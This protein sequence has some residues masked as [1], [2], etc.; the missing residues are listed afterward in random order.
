LI[1]KPPLLGLSRLRGAGLRQDWPAR[2]PE[3]ERASRQGKPFLGLFA[4]PGW[5]ASA[6]VLV[7]S[8]SILIYLLTRL[9]GL[10]SFPIF[11]FSDEAVQTVMAADFVR[12]DFR[13]YDQV[14]L[15]TYFINGPTYNLSSVSVYLQVVP[16]LLFGKSI[17]VTRSVSVAAGV[18]AA[19]AVALS[20]R[21]VFKIPFWWSGILLLSITPAWFYHS[22]TA[23]EAV[24]MTAFYAAFLYFYLQ[25]R[26][27][28]PRFLYPALFF[29]ALT[30]YTYGPGQIIMVVSGLLL[31]FSDLGYH[32]RNRW[33]GV[34]GLVLLAVLAL[35]YLRFILG[36][37]G[38]P[39]DQL[40][41]RAPFWVQPA[42]LG[43][44][45]TRFIANYLG[46]INPLYWYFPQKHEL[47]R[48]LM[49]G[50]GHLFWPAIPLT[51]VGLAAAIKNFRLPAYR[52]LWIALAAV[53]AGSA[54]VGV[55]ITRLLP[56][57]IPITIFTALG[58]SWTICRLRE[59]LDSSRIAG[60]PIKRP[61]RPAGR[62]PVGY[63]SLVV[64]SILA[65]IN[66][67]MLRDGLVNGATWFQDYSLNGMQY[68]ARQ[69]FS[70][71]QETLERGPD[72]EIILSPTW[73]NGADVVARFFLGDPLPIQMG[74]I[75]GHLMEKRTLTDRTLFIMTPEEYQ[76]TLESEKF[77]R[78][79][80]EQIIP[81]PNGEPGF[82]FTRLAY[83]DQIDHI[84]AEEREQRRHLVE[85]EISFEGQQ[86][87][88]RHSQLDIGEI[89]QLFD[90]D[91]LSP[92]RTLEANPFV[93]EIAFSE[94][95]TIS[96]ISLKVSSIEAGLI[97][98][99]YPY[100]G[101]EALEFNDV[102]RGTVER[103]E[104]QLDFGQSVSTAVFHLE[105]KDIHQPEPGHVHIWELRLH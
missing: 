67:W 3:K 103:P 20:L 87:V 26:C 92:V 21:G 63:A 82:Y 84:L 28:S 90:G 79:D 80:T 11:F 47:S 29:G 1:G 14:F 74:S 57:I 10:E 23:F 46:G 105:V 13:N 35:P 42:P 30:F 97:V 78:V 62:M 98:R 77:S 83:V 49:G 8:G 75:N 31:L 36:Q 66:L 45:I 7:V 64:F 72:T 59:L 93:V 69:V 19:L 52:V 86:V 4:L 38:V 100:E 32:W 9:I 60:P 37:G 70:A 39:F 33:T 73:T 81:Y 55:G 41:L 102:Q 50:Y 54:L 18:L 56:L 27:R 94:A 16:Y 53:P 104:V 43:E 15:P 2:E 51:L 88:V 6:S 76:R 89:D 99:L 91:L 24:E 58:L 17:F 44:K 101:T 40:T 85:K 5:H 61:G 71:V 95:R 48:H 22:R 68:G 25:Y 96:G 34:I 12:D 65:F